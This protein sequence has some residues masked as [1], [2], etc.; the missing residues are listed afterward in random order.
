MF[1]DLRPLISINGELPTVSGFRVTFSKTKPRQCREA[2]QTQGR[3]AVG[4]RPQSLAAASCWQD[5]S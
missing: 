5:V 2:V 4:P 3:L 1:S